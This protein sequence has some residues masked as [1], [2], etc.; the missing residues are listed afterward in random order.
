MPL[1]EYVCDGCEVC[2]EDFLAVS[3][4]NSQV[5]ECGAKARRMV[6]SGV[7]LHGAIWDKKI[8]IGGLDQTFNTNAEYRQY[9]KEHPN[10]STVSTKDPKWKAMVQASRDKADANCR[11]WGFKD[12]H[13]WS[14]THKKEAAKG[15]DWT[16][17]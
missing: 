9:M 17:H 13:H 2:W 10:E 15:G 7:N 8:H 4:R 6:S 16:K 1:Y 14:E 5:C 3:E 12:H 11:K